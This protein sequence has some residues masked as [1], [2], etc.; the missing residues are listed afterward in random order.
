MPPSYLVTSRTR[1]SRR[2]RT[3][4]RRAVMASPTSTSYG[5]NPRSRVSVDPLLFTGRGF[6]A[7]SYA[8]GPAAPFGRCVSHSRRRRRR[9]RGSQPWVTTS[10]PT[11]PVPDATGRAPTGAA[12]HPSGDRPRCIPYP[13][14]DDSS[15]RP[16]GHGAEPR[17]GAR[18]AESNS[19]LTSE[20]RDSGTNLRT[21]KSPARHD[22]KG[23]TMTDSKI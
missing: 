15:P 1:T 8:C 4:S 2:W 6:V 14:L 3:A 19:L 21:R 20:S 16:P 22:S 13:W 9:A 17:R 7:G 12:R 5:V 23:R 10:G 18:A 11:G